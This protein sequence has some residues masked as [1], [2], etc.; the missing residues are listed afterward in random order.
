MPFTWV[1]ASGKVR[2]F[3]ALLRDELD[4]FISEG[5]TAE[6]VMRTQSQ[7]KASLF[8]GMES[9]MAR[10]NRL[11]KSELL[12]GK[13]TPWKRSSKGVCSDTSDGAGLCSG[14]PGKTSLYSGGYR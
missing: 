10:M 3:F 2:E 4:R 14:D 8:L 1:R 9:V 5:V 7:I 6:E 13:V 11:G 12:Y